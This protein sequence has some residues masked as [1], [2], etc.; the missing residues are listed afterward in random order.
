MRSYFLTAF[1][2]A[3]TSFRPNSQG[4]LKGP[5]DIIESRRVHDDAFGGSKMWGFGHQPQ[6]KA[7]WTGNPGNPEYLC[8]CM[9]RDMGGVALHCKKSAFHSA[10]KQISQAPPKHGTDL[11]ELVAVSCVSSWF[12]DPSFAY[13]SRPLDLRNCRCLGHW[14]A[15]K[16]DR[17]R[18]AGHSHSNP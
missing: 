8:T 1:G 5:V 15:I 18:R 10:R 13:F 9:T 16:A 14:F 6:P 7:T 4:S 3:C 17:A 11:T 12:G 2:N